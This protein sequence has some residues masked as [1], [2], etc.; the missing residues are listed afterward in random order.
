MA[1]DGEAALMMSA[2]EDVLVSRLVSKAVSNV[3]N[4]GPELLDIT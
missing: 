1:R 3:K 4:N 2:N